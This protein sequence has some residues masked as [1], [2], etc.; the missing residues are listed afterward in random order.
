MRRLVLVTALAVLVVGCTDTTGVQGTTGGDARVVVLNGVGETGV[1]FVPLDNAPTAHIDFGA[2]FDGAVFTVDHDSV[3]STSSAFAGDQLFVADLAARTVQPV[4]LPAGSNPGGARFRPDPN[5]GAHTSQLFV[6]L[7]NTGQLAFIDLSAPTVVSVS[8]GA[9]ACPA[10]IVVHGDDVWSVD[11]N[12][13]CASDFSVQ[14]NGRLIRVPLDGSDPDTVDLG[15]ASVSAQ[16]AVVSGDEAFVLSGGDF[17][18]TPGAVSRVNLASHQVTG[19][20]PLPDGIFGVSLALGNDGKL[21]VTGAG[22][23]FVP[24]LFIVDPASLTFVNGA[25]AGDGHI[26]LTKDD[27]SEASCFAAIGEANGDILCV[28]NGDVTATVLRFDASGTF[29]DSAPAGSPAFDI[30]IR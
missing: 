17:V 3:L 14:G 5:T 15:S 29:I 18:S 26:V 30:A 13:A 9:G 19:T 22:T 21:Y 16:R 10:D 4:Q 20:L 24:R 1:T 25:P 28:E 12:L 11:E 2:S 27:G 23:P 6:A 8:D 7:R